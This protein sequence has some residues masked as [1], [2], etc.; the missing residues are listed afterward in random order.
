MI[1]ITS[2]SKT[3]PG[4][5]ALREVDL[6]IEPGTIH[7]IFGPN[8]AG[9][10]TLLKVLAGLTRPDVGMVKLNGI[11]VLKQPEEAR[12]KMG[13]QLELPAVY[14][15]LTLRQYLSFFGRLGGLQGK[16]LAARISYVLEMLEMGNLAHARVQKFSIGQ[17]QRMEIGRALLHDPQVL[18]L[19]EP[20]IALDYE[21]RKRLA[22]YLRK[23]ADDGRIVIATS[24]NLNEAKRLIDS[25]SLI[26]RGVLTTGEQAQKE[27]AGELYHLHTTDDE[28][29]A[30]LFKEL[31]GLLA[32][33]PQQGH[34]RLVLDS[35]NRLPA[36][37]ECLLEKDVK[38]VFMEASSDL[39]A[40][41]QEL[42][43]R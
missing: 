22:D 12:A 23:F 32:C 26:S 41:Y 33:E 24:H 27:L 38:P 15:E 20:F 8:G 11:D 25:Y 13:I 2:V 29:A 14:D 10:T 19:D 1:S 21:F 3:Y 34:L 43:H 37:L 4:V 30:E 9:K 17:R 31:E 35:P 28:K 16:N 6:E 7:G 36:L 39:E 40:S 18:M 42:V 5:Q